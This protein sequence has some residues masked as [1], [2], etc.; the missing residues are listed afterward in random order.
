MTRPCVFALTIAAALAGPA[1]A[2]GAPIPA[3]VPVRAA[4]VSAP[5]PLHSARESRASAGDRFNVPFNVEVHPQ[6]LP[7]ASL[8]A[9]LRLAPEPAKEWLPGYRPLWYVPACFAN[10]TFGNNPFG[11]PPSAS[12]SSDSALNQ[13]TIGSLVDSKSRTL[14]SSTPSHNPGLPANVASFDDSSPLSWQYQVQASPCGP[15]SP[16]AL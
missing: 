5:L 13:V 1:A 9:P 15:S 10:N 6:P 16:L 11:T 7:E 4:P 8:H 12:T 14:F 2:L 3:A